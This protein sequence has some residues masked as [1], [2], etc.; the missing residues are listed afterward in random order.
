M[1]ISYFLV[2]A[3]AKQANHPKTQIPSQQIYYNVTEQIKANKSVAQSAH[4]QCEP[5]YVNLV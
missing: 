2:S 5:V 4:W 3:G 1:Q